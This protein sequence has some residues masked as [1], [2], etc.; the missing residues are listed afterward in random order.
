MTLPKAVIFAFLLL[1]PIG[2]FSKGQLNIKTGKWTAQLHLR[3]NTKL[4]FLLIVEGKGKN[5]KLSVVNG[6]ETILLEKGIVNGDSVQFEFPAFNSRLTL[7]SKGK[8]MLSGYWINLNKSNYRIPFTA[9][10]GYETRF[11]AEKS[12]LSLPK[13]WEITFDPNSESPYKSVGLFEQNGNKVEGTF[14][15]ETGDYRFLEGN[16]SNDS[17]Y[18]SCFDGSHAFLFAS[19]ITNDSIYGDFYS[20]KHWKGNWNGQVNEAFELQHPDSLTYTINEAP[21]TFTLKDL[22]GNDFTFPQANFK[23][24]VTI[25]Q[26]MGTWCPNCM[27]ETQYFKKL[28]DQYNNSG[29]EIISVGYEIGKDFNE[30]AEKI[31]RLQ[32]RYNLP[33]TFLVGGNANKGLASEHFSMLNKIIS[34]PT[35]IFIG[36]DGSVK[37]IHTGFNGPGTGI[38]YKEYTRETELF[39]QSL[40]QEK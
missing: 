33:F 8:K 20:G 23:N 19:R 18:L 39:I 26:I 16:I 35:A 36:R 5:T 27:D 30:H 14:L 22:Q 17:L 4:P 6:T 25:I 2:L 31:R 28:H 10:Y 32:E 9:V 15:T 37:K 3:E 11:K 40:L 13:K 7:V 29:L 38:Y 34:F 1:V 21:F 12:N 24:K